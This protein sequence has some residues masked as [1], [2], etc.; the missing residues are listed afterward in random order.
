MRRFYGILIAFVLAVPIGLYLT[1]AS[2]WG[3]WEKEYY[4]KALGFIPGKIESTSQSAPI[5]DYALSGMGDVSSYYLSAAVGVALIFA[6]FYLLKR[7]V[8]HD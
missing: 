2:A 7:F 5:P 3:E 1:D 8:R 6:F 4:Q